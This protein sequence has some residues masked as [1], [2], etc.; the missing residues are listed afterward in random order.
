VSH[1]PLAIVSVLAV[2]DY[3]LWNWSLNGN[4]D[5]LALVSGLTL[6][7]LAIACIWLFAL[8]VMRLL[9]HTVNRSRPPVRTA[10]EVRVSQGAREA[11][12]SSGA[13]GL[14][15]VEADE[16]A[17]ADDG[18]HGRMAPAEGAS[19]SRGELAA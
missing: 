9:A 16:Q 7:P 18:E 3:L 15:Q 1:R 17:D 2:G 14:A 19:Q 12:A 11:A 5:V 6:P 4:H 10:A 8:S 13:G